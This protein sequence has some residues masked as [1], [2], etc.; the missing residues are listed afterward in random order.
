MIA[1]KYY[2]LTV[3]EAVLKPYLEHSVEGE[4]D[5]IMTNNKTPNKY[6]IK[7]PVGAVKPAMFNAWPELDHEQFRIEN[8][9]D[10]WQDEAMKDF[11]PEKEET[12]KK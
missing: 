8:R 9:K 12:P 3:N 2:I 10:E 4:D 6:I 1:N 5:S 11:P 7:L